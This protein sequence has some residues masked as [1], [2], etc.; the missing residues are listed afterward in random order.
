VV[1]GAGIGGLL[2]ARVLSELYDQVTVVERDAL[3]AEGEFRS[4]VPQGRHIHGLLARGGQILDRLFP[5]FL[6]G[7]AAQGVPTGDVL[8]DVRWYL[9]G[10]RLARTRSGLTGLSITRPHLEYEIRNRLATV[11]NVVLDG[12]C[13]VLGFETAAGADAVSGVRVARPDGEPADRV[14]AADLVVDASGRGSR[15]PQWLAAMGYL[16]PDEERVR[17]DVGYST[18]WF[19]L[20]GDPLGGDIGIVVGATPTNLRGGAISR[21]SGGRW[22]VSLGGYLG[23]HPPVTPDG[24]LR[25]AAD[26]P[27]PD[28]YRAIRDGTPLGKP[29]RYRYPEARRRN[30]QR[31]ARFPDGL[32][33]LGDAACSFNP[34]Y[35]QGMSVAAAQ[36]LTL[37]EHL[38]R[39]GPLPRLRREVAR[40]SSTAWKMS[41]G[42][43]LRLPGI[44]GRRTPAV[45]L[46]NAYASRLY[47]AARHDPVLG[48][49]FIRVA[50]LVDPPR[51]LLRPGVVLRVLT[52]DGGGAGRTSAADVTGTDSGQAEAR[53]DSHIRVA[54]DSG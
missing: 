54:E 9:E 23:D 3:P 4:G 18:C 50:N 31:L 51:A 17:V 48:S 6:D 7:L 10:S 26:L 25:F 47:R 27:V 1:I 46:S 49:A 32:V 43:D 24:F 19:D 11:D 42:G 53:I 15:T 12:P 44:P 34:I 52:P 16:P 38:R 45:R 29:V 36:A 2:A 37:S 33:V 20:P 39:A 13:T 21:I 40:T 30:Y 35:G 28:I 5:G 8:E 41:V 22:L 14:L